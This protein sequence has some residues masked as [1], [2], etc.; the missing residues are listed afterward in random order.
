[1]FAAVLNTKNTLYFF[2]IRKKRGTLAENPEYF[3]NGNRDDPYATIPDHH[4]RD[5]DRMVD[6]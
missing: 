1:M 2:S 3:E 4:V 6:I 5:N